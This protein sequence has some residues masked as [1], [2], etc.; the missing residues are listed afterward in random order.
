MI[1]N[2]TQKNDNN[3]PLNFRPAAYL[4]AFLNPVSRTQLKESINKADETLKRTDILIAKTDALYQ[5][6]DNALLK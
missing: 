4:L 1:S 5:R 6:V 2:K 3:A